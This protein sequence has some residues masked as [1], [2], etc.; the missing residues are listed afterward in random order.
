MDVNWT[1]L[2]VNVAVTANAPVASLEQ[3]VIVPITLGAMST[4]EPAA[5]TL[6]VNG[7]HVTVLPPVAEIETVAD[8][9]ASANA[10]P[11]IRT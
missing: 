1:P 2:T 6:P 9:L 10:E 5:F 7:P 8:L 3:R 4:G 11:F